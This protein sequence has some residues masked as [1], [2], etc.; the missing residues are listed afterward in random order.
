MALAV[1][2]PVCNI[3][4]PKSVVAVGCFR[5]KPRRRERHNPVHARSS[6]LNGSLKN[7]LSSS[8]LWLAGLCLLAVGALIFRD[9]LFDGAVLLYTDIGSDSINSYYPDFVSLS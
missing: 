3:V 1:F 8:S 6:A 5:R 9:F 2:E 4:G 7:C